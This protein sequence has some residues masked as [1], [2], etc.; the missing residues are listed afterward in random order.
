MSRVRLKV[1]ALRACAGLLAPGSSPGCLQ[2]NAGGTCAGRSPSEKAITPNA[3]LD[4]GGSGA[5]G[6]VPLWRADRIGDCPVP[7]GLEP[8]S[9]HRHQPLLL[10]QHQQLQRRA[11]SS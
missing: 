1:A 3:L 5:A 8:P 10:H 4:E 7:L 6:R 11:A 2:L 9:S